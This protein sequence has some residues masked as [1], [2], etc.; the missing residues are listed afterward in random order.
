[1]SARLRLTLSYAAIVVASGVALMAV[2][3]WV[4]RF[5][6]E[7]N[8][9]ADGTFAPDRSDLLRAFLPRALEV[10]AGLVVVGLAGGWL[11]AG[12]MLRPLDRIGAVARRVAAGSLDHRVHL[13]GPH[14]EFRVLADTFDAMLDRVQAQM[15]ERRRFAA[16]ASHELRTPYTI[17]RSVIDV[18]LA[19]P[20]G[21][22]VDEVL[23]RLDVTN[24]RGM[25]AVEALLA[26]STLDHGAAVDRVPVDLAEVAAE[27]LEELRPEADAAGVALV[28][29]LGEGD[30]DG[31]PA[32]VRQLVSNLVINSIRHN[33]P[34][35][36]RAELQT[37]TEG[38]GHVALRVRNTGPVVAP[39]VLSTATEPFV[40]GAGRVAHGTSQRGSG[41]GLAIV[42]RV[43]AAHDAKLHLDAPGEGGLDVRVSFPKPRASDASGA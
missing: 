5:V 23:R 35:G 31:D 1:V 37:G 12:R 25:E 9:T 15:D 3:F 18:A 41:L 28:G 17:S 14:D 10:L 36:G 34:A 29:E 2:V 38:D 40:R 33:L 19:D 16:N 21:R 26:L 11:L 22:D 32:L 13:D 30:T 43:A 4:L 42:A 6:P 39:D 20:D 8:L 7:G 24:R 27:V